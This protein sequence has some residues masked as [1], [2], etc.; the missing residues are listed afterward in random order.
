MNGKRTFLRHFDI[1][2]AC[3]GASFFAWQRGVPQSVYAGDM[4]MMTSAIGALVVFSAIY[5]GVQAWRVETDPSIDV[6]FGETVYLIA[7]SLG[8]LGTTIGLQLRTAAAANSD[9]A[10]GFVALSTCLKSTA[11]GVAALI[12][13]LAMTYNLSVGIKRARR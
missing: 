2:L 3:A 11:C 1:C 4:S 6:E 12:I 13:L 8:L 7:P 10:A 5:I 9:A